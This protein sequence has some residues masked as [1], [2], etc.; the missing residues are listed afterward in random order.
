MYSRY[1]NVCAAILSVAFVVSTSV[2]D[3]DDP[4]FAVA[5]R[6]AFPVVAA[7]TAFRLVRN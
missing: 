6:I 2:V 4:T 5:G 3:A 1:A 7:F